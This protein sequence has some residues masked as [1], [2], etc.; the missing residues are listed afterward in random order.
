MA[1]RDV[2]RVMQIADQ[3]VQLILKPVQD[4][5]QPLAELITSCQEVKQMME[6][7]EDVHR[8]YTLAS[9]LEGLPRHTS[10][11][12]AGIIMAKGE[13][14]A[15]TPSKGWVIVANSIRAGDLEA[16]DWLSGYFRTPYFNHHQKCFD[17]I[18]EIQEQNFASINC[19]SKML[20]FIE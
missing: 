18:K 17:L 12:A 13:L 8:L 5:P 15:Y 4:H 7:N 6:S 10:T 14:V 16:W 9:K 1:I 11:H 2:A 19:R 3:R 20:L